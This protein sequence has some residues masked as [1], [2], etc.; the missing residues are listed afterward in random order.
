MEKFNLSGSEGVLINK[1]LK[2]IDDVMERINS[3]HLSHKDVYNL[4]IPEEEI[5]ALKTLVYDFKMFTEKGI[6]RMPNGTI[7]IK[8]EENSHAEKIF[9]IW[10]IDYN[11]VGT[12]I[13]FKEADYKQIEHKIESGKKFIEKFHLED[14]STFDFNL[15]SKDHRESIVKDIKSTGLKHKQEDLIWLDNKAKDKFLDDITYIGQSEDFLRVSDYVHIDLSNKEFYNGVY[16]EVERYMPYAIVPGSKK[17]EKNNRLVIE[18]K[19]I[20]G[21]K[22]IIKKYSSKLPYWKDSKGNFYYFDTKLRMYVKDVEPPENGRYLGTY[23]A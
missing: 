20:K 4:S 21:V 5:K 8:S 6:Q 3:K 10:G 14:N 11:K 22:D 12:D 17:D 19:H 16:E 15:E 23:N 7:L 18:K 9:D 1:N 2:H 13:F